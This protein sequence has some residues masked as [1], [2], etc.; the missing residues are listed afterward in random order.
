MST[1]NDGYIAGRT[2][3]R[4][5]LCKRCGKRTLCIEIDTLT[6]PQNMTV[7]ATILQ[8]RTFEEPTLIPFVGVGC[9]CYAKFHRQLAHINYSRMSTGAA[10]V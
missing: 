6:L 9:G 3:T 10:L 7:K 8:D 4:Q 2:S 1:V 5:R